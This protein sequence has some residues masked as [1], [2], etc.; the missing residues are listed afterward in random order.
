M[1]NRAFVASFVG[2]VLLATVACV[3]APAARVQGPAGADFLVSSADTGRP[4]GELVVVQRSDPRTLNPVTVVDASSREIIRRLHAGLLHVDPGTQRVEPALAK[5][6]TASPDGSRYRLTLRTGLQFSDGDAFDADD[7]V[8]SFRV[9]LDEKLASPHR[10]LLLV[11]GKPMVVRK[12]DQH[13]IDFELNGPYAVGERLFD[14]LAMLPRHLLQKPYE[15]GRLGEMWSPASASSEIAGLGPFRLK[16]H[17]PGERIVLERNPHYWKVDRAGTRLPYLDRLVFTIVPS[18]DAQAVRFQSGEADVITRLS[19]ANFDVLAKDARARNYELTDLGPGLEY[20]FLFFNLNNLEGKPLPAIARKQA[21]FRQEAFRRAVSLATDREGIA[22][23]VYRN[24]ASPLWGHVPPGNT[25]VNHALPKPPRSVARA[26]ELLREAGFT[27]RKDGTL[28]DAS[29]SP[30]AFSIATNSE[31]AERVQIATILQD[32]LKQLGMN[33][34]V[35]T[36]ELRALTGRLLTTHDYEAAVLGLGGGDADPNVEMGV[37]L[38]TG[39]LHLWNLGQQTPATPWEAE[40]D[41][42]MHQQITVRDARERRRLYDRV[43]AVV[44]EHLPIVP[45]VSPHVLVGARAGLGNFRPTVLPDHTLWNVEELY[46]R[47]GRS[48]A[49]R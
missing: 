13:T 14:N 44:A 17:V 30:V 15:E 40:I 43:Q 22:R 18:A 38:S 37:W 48:G 46:W 45:L 47:E 28:A 32:D 19:A 24:R 26:R 35:V 23:L 33:V 4:G 16:E 21:W 1:M 5:S 10:D 2:R 9:Y 29:G 12:I 34:S 20:T 11:G 25:W 8:F 49:G 3:A 27:W 31:N 39:G 36:T 7:V 42:L 6:W 41:K